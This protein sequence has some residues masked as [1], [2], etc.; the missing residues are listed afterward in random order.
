MSLT[1]TDVAHVAELA[2]LGLTSDERERLREQ[3]SSIL[4]HIEVL[5][6]LDTDEIAPTAQV[7]PLI[8]VMRED[9]ATPSLSRDDALANAP[10]TS[11]GFFAV[12]AVLTGSP[13]D[14][15]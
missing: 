1:G 15:A 9:M 10:H 14:P 3:L 7:L 4:G 11:D 5:E 2:R 6:R 12:Q 8:N 13:G